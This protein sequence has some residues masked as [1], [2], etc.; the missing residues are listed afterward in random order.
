MYLRASSFLPCEALTATVALPTLTSIAYDIMPLKRP[1]PG[2]VG[3]RYEQWCA[4]SLPWSRAEHVMPADSGSQCSRCFTLN[5][6]LGSIFGACLN[7]G[8]GLSKSFDHAL[9]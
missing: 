4:A 5:T 9:L 1:I 7:L 2:W 3:S 6:W 8:L